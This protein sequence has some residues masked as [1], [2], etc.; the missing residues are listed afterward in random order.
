MVDDYKIRLLKK[1]EAKL[2]KQ[3][4]ETYK[5]IYGLL[6]AVEILT[7]QLKMGATQ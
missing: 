1:E 3:I 2:A 5:E 6:N 4:Q 7:N